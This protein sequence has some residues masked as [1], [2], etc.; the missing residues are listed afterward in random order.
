[1]TESRPYWPRGGIPR[2]WSQGGPRVDRP[3]PEGGTM[4]V[5]PPVRPSSQVPPLRP[6]RASGPAPLYLGP[7]PEQHGWVP[8]IPSLL[9]TRYTHPVHPPG[10]HQLHGTPSARTAGTLGTCTYDRFEV[11]VGEPRGVEHSLISGSRAG[12]YCI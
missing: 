10:M 11:N 8:G 1:M 7:L 2:V 12:L 5:Q 6:C 3:G 4:P 9:P